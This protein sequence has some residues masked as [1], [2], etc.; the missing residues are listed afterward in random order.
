MVVERQIETPYVPI[1]P[2][3]FL[4]TELKNVGLHELAQVNT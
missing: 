3:L 4:L 2:F 1:S